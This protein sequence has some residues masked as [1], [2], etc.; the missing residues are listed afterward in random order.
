MQC[1]VSVWMQ[2][3]NNNLAGETWSC[4][5]ATRHGVQ[6]LAEI[7]VALRDVL[8]RSVLDPLATLPMKLGWDN[9]STQRKQLRGQHARKTGSTHM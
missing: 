9:T 3:L 7:N 2:R 6:I 4:Q 5:M 8:E 1:S